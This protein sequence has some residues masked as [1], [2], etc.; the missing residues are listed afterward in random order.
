MPALP[1][2]VKLLRRIDRFAWYAYHAHEI[3]RDEVLFAWLR[4]ELR[5]ELTLLAY[6]DMATYLPGGATYQGGLFPWERQLLSHS[7]IPKG[8]RVLLG[9]AGGGRE[10][11]ALAEAGYE[12]VAFEPNPT[13]LGGARATAERFPGTRVVSAAY[14]DLVQAATAGSG[15]LADLVKSHFDWVLLG[16]GSFTHVTEPADQLALLRALRALVPNGPVAF[17]FFLRKAGAEVPSRS[18]RLRDGARAAL[19]RL[20]T[21]EP[22]PPGLGYEFGGGFVYN[23]TE[24]DIGALAHASGYEV[25]HFDASAFPYAILRPIAP[26]SAPGS[27]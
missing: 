3:V 22:P 25:A 1:V 23:F 14:G 24:A 15:P 2:W 19:R 8:G 10:L 18:Q 20:G 26:G 21:N 9:A 6:S 4:P 7:L 11:L 16:W 12:V 5:G 13:L 27:V 17:S